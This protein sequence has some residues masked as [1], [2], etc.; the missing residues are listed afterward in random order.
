MVDNHLDLHWLSQWQSTT[1]YK[2]NS[3]MARNSANYMISIR[4]EYDA[5]LLLNSCDT[6]ST[7]ADVN[8]YRFLLF[9]MY[10]DSR[11]EMAEK[12]K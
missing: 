7:G 10:F 9:V 8:I 6:E 4:F 1:R 11:V 3:F 2:N 12:V 5:S